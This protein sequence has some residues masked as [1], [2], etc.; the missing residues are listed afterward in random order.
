MEGSPRGPG[1]AVPLGI[2]ILAAAFF[3]VGGVSAAPKQVCQGNTI[4]A[5]AVAHEVQAVRLPLMARSTAKYPWRVREWDV[6][7]SLGGV[8][9]MRGAPPT[10]RSDGARFW[11]PP[12][13]RD[14]NPRLTDDRPVGGLPHPYTTHFGQ[15]GLWTI[16][17]GRPPVGGFGFGRSLEN[18]V[19]DSARD[20]RKHQRLKTSGIPLLHP[21]SRTEE[22]A[23]RQSLL[24]GGLDSQMMASSSDVPK[25]CDPSSPQDTNPISQTSDQSKG[26]R[27]L[28]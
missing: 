28:T 11:G 24:P 3:L 20:A 8:G 10:T 7:Q 5:R 17:E 23:L 12:S 26:S 21:K 6:E 18:L 15:G 27:L 16:H 14:A 9:N 1:R 2:R 19:A 13:P 22:R 25:W 4:P